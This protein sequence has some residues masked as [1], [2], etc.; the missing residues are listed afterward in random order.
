MGDGCETA[1][2]SP[3]KLNPHGAPRNGTGFRLDDTAVH[4]IV[5]QPVRPPKHRQLAIRI[6]MHPHRR[7]D[8]V[9]P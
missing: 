8:E 3:P 5:C 7:L 1:A 6:L 4:G 2:V 9:R